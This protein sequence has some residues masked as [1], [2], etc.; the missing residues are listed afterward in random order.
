MVKGF[1]F[2]FIFCTK[3][4]QE[5]VFPKPQTPQASL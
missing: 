5:R 4:K 2:E 1:D 3:M